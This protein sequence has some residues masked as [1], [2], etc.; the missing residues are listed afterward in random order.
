[1]GA[2][3]IS[4]YP[5]VTKMIMCEVMPF[6]A[7]NDL[8]QRD[9]CKETLKLRQLWSYLLNYLITSICHKYPNALN[10]ISERVQN[11]VE[12]LS[13]KKIFCM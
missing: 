5:T 2:E 6:G 12:I 8:M 13:L 4:T 7:N 11:K 10:K 3:I 1:M 9:S